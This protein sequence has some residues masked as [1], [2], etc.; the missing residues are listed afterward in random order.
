MKIAKIVLCVSLAVTLT[1]CFEVTQYVE[2]IGGKTYTEIRVITPSELLDVVSDTEITE[3]LDGM[4]AT[5]EEGGDRY[6]KGVDYTFKKI[7][8]ASETGVVLTYAYLPALEKTIAKED[9]EFL[10]YMDGKKLV[11]P[12]AA[13]FIDESLIEDIDEDTAALLAVSLALAKYRFFISKS[14][15]AKPKKAYVVVNGTTRHAASLR[16]Y[17]DISIVDVPISYVLDADTLTCYIE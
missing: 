17:S 3:N 13:G 14:I 10:P 7:S 8:D 4:I 16:T 12:M 5:L 9:Y 2:R 11:I 15:M 1:S 6:P